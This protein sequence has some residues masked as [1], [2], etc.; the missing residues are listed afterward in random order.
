[1]IGQIGQEKKRRRRA[2]GE[3]TAFVRRDLPTT[4]ESIPRSQQEGAAGVQGRIDRWE[5][6]Q[7]EHRSAFLDQ[8]LEMDSEPL[9][10]R[11]LLTFIVAS[12]LG[13]A[14]YEDEAR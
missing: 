7:G 6:R 14:V 3:H 11:C 12:Y 9:Q 1:M 8:Y 5:V 10:S 4:N 13:A 2:G